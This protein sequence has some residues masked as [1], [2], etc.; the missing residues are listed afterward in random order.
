MTPIEALAAIAKEADAASACEDWQTFARINLIAQTAI[1]IAQTAIATAKP[2]PVSELSAKL[3][4]PLAALFAGRDVYNI[5]PPA[6][7]P[8]RIEAADA[9]DRQAAEIAASVN[10]EQWLRKQ[11]LEKDATIVQ[12]RADYAKQYIKC[13]LI[14]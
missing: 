14:L 4:Q 1:L 3:R 6:I 12:L 8:V 13:T 2:A 10:Y 9:L 7:D 5:V 11:C